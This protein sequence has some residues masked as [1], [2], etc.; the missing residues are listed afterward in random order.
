MNHNLQA[1]QAKFKEQGY[2]LEP[3]QEKDRAKL[4]EIYQEV[5][6]AGTYFPHDDSSCEE[7]QRCFFAPGSHVYVCKSAEEVLGAFYLKPNFPG[8]GNHIANAAYM[9]KK[10]A[11]GK[12][13]GKLLGE[14]SLYLAKAIGFQAIQLNV[15]LSQNLPAIHLYKKLGFHIIGTIPQAIRTPNGSYQA[16]YIMYRALF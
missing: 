15:V 11:R 10:T 13:L 6:E 1:I 14:S 7:F 12:G 2:T 5:I 4:Y 3:Y 16:G 8:R 9:I